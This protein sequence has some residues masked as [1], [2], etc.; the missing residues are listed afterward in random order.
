MMPRGRVLADSVSTLADGSTGRAAGADVLGDSRAPA[1]PGVTIALL[2][3]ASE[4]K[5]G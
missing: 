3:H 2:D 4:E 1:R 5:L